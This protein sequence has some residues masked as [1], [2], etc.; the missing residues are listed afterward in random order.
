MK[1]Y[2]HLWLYIA[3]FF[4][5]W[6]MFTDNKNTILCSINPPPKS[7][8]L[9]DVEKYGT[10]DYATRRMRSACRITKSTDKHT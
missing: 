6:E 7:C 3:E 2:V 8:R 10:A 5:E 4:L 1:T 9:W